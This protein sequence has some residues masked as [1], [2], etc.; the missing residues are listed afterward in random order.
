[1]TIA[2]YQQELILKGLMAVE[3]LP[4]SEERANFLEAAACLITNQQLAERCNVTARCLR[5]AEMAQLRLF[6]SLRP[7]A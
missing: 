3:S 4:S 1:M 5:E 7:N 6:N 2:Q